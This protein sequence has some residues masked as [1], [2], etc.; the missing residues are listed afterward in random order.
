MIYYLNLSLASIAG[1]VLED[2]DGDYL[3]GALLPALHHLPER[4][5]P[6]ELQHLVPVKYNKTLHTMNS[7]QNESPQLDI[8]LHLRTLL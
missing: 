1:V 4:T 2:L 8:G 6:E 3:V 5:S 7:V